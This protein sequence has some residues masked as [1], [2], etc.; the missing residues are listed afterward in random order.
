MEAAANVKAAPTVDHKAMVAATTPTLSKKERKLLRNAAMA[1]KSKKAKKKK[2]KKTAASGDG[3]TKKLSKSAKK[4]Q[5]KAATAT[6]PRPPGEVPS[7][8]SSIITNP[9]QHNDNSAQRPAKKARSMIFGTTRLSWGGDEVVRS[10]I[11]CDV[12][13]HLKKGV[14]YELDS[15]DGGYVQVS[16]LRDSTSMWRQVL[17]VGDYVDGRMELNKKW[18]ECKVVECDA[19]SVTLH[20]MGWAKT[21]NSSFART[22]PYIQK[23]HTN[24]PSWRSKL[25]LSQEVEVASSATITPTTEWKLLPITGI[26][27]AVPSTKEPAPL[28]GAIRF[29]PISLHDDI[30]TAM[31]VQF[32]R[33]KKWVSAITDKICLRGTHFCS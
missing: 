19:D 32:G 1:T 21:F 11:R 7:A 14:T 18:F 6:T 2:K 10:F 28:P 3:A 23:L 13:V 22:S 30:G 20:F 5:R 16:E 29:N 27:A 17:Q 4:E 25:K 26:R 12:D 15:M 31:E 8:T 33:S 24:V 9:F